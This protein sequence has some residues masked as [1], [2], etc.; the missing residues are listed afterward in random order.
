M[1]KIFPVGMMLE[2]VAPIKKLYAGNSTKQIRFAL[3]HIAGGFN[4]ALLFL[5]AH[6]RGILL[7]QKPRGQ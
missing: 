5:H 3:D 2:I 1:P 7:S 6:Q 4:G